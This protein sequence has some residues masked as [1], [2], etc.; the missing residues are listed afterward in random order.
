MEERITFHTQA[1][2]DGQQTTFLVKVSTHFCKLEN[3]LKLYG[4]E[5]S[6]YGFK[7]LCPKAATWSFEF[8]LL[9]ASC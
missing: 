9:H 2:Q 6:L 5:M 4:S 3:I 1:R 7:T 8:C